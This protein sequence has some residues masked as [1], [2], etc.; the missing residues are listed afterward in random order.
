VSISLWICVKTSA[1]V[2]PARSSTFQLDKRERCDLRYADLSTTYGNYSFDTVTLKGAILSNFSFTTADIMTHS[3]LVGDHFGMLGL[4]TQGLED[5]YQDACRAGDCSKGVRT[6]TIT[7]ALVSAGHIE[8]PCYSLFLDDRRSQKGSILFGGI[9]TA[10][11]TGPLVTLH[12]TPEDN[13]THPIPYARQQLRLTNL[14]M[15]SS[16]YY[17]RN[18]GPVLAADPVNTNDTTSPGVTVQI[19]TGHNAIMVPQMWAENVM[20]DLPIHWDLTRKYGTHIVLCEDADTDR[21]LTFTLEDEA[22]DSAQID[23]PFHELLVPIRKRSSSSMEPIL[24]DGKQLCYLALSGSQGDG[25]SLGDP[26]LRSAYTFYNLEQH[27][28]SLVQAANN[29]TGENIVPIGKGPMR[30]LSGTG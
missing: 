14:T 8:T 7:D 16:G 17:R 22:G 12:T 10:K 6:P 21:T 3:R 1:I 15:L 18:Y 13:V 29:S 11:F 30:K 23:V 25:S 28:I 4:S 24:E 5:D 27:T 19:D 26:F 20:H 9:D 2:D